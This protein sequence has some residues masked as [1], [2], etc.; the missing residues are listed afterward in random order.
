VLAG[1]LDGE[2]VSVAMIDHKTNI[3]YP[4]Y[5][6][7]RGYGLFAANPLGAK[8]FS[9]G[10]SEVNLVLKKGEEKKFQYRIVIHSGDEITSEAMNKLAADFNRK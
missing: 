6:H 9:E 10:K 1:K 2:T 4:T 7:A 8:I 3:G 5:W